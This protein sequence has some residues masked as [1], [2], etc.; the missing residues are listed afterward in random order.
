MQEIPQEKIIKRFMKENENFQ[1]LENLI[2]TE[3]V[4][5]LIKVY[6]KKDVNQRHIYFPTVSS[7]WRIGLIML[8]ENEDL[9]EEK[10]K[11]IRQV[12]PSKSLSK[13][14]I[15]KIKKTGKYCYRE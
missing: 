12:F 9:T 15:K 5:K 2:G 1:E 13:K 14:Q 6:S 3:N 11:E 10:I 7:L 4:I 8:I